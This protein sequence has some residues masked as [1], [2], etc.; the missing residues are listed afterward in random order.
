MSDTPW[1][2]TPCWA[3][4]PDNNTSYRR[5][6]AWLKMTESFGTATTFYRNVLKLEDAARGH[7][8][9]A[10]TSHRTLPRNPTPA[11]PNPDSA[12]RGTGVL[13][14]RCTRAAILRLDAAARWQLQEEQQRHESQTA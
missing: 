9:Q 1:S 4:D 5:P 10:V 8:P 11:F 7:T 2:D 14:P 6:K 13:F 3:R 12:G